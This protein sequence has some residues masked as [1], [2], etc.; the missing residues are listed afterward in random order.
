MTE[1]T[2]LVAMEKM[3]RALEH[4]QSQ[5]L[6]VR[7]GRA[8]S[9]LVDK[10]SVDYYGVCGSLAATCNVPGSRSENADH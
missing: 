5:F 2:L 10:L 7:T 3:A 6:G 8:N 1:E 4:V 9:S